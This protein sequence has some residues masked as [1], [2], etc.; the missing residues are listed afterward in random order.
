MFPSQRRGATEN[1]PRSGPDARNTTS[2]TTKSATNSQM[3]QAMYRPATDVGRPGTWPVTTTNAPGRQAASTP[4]PIDCAPARDR[5]EDRQG[6]VD[7]EHHQERGMDPAH[8]A[9]HEARVPAPVLAHLD[10]RAVDQVAAQHEEQ[11]DARVADGREERRRLRRGG[12]WRDPPA[13]QRFVV[14]E[15]HQRD[16]QP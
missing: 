8:A 9:A 12:A 5:S 1:N 13:K 14:H 4:A 2:V 3:A 15:E 6:D 7:G 10:D 16:R 11:I